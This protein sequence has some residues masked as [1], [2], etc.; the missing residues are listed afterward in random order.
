MFR[1]H[2]GAPGLA[3]FQTWVTH[4][5]VAVHPGLEPRESWGTLIKIV[6]NYNSASCNTGFGGG[7]VCSASTMA[8][9][10]SVVPALPPTSRVMCF[11]SP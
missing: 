10:N 5:A 3:I 6:D 11:F 4:G 2:L 1:V 7:M 8:S 9:A